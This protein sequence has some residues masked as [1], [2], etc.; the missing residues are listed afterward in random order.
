MTSPTVEHGFGSLLVQLGFRTG[1]RFA[2]RLAPLGLEPRQF[3]ALSRIA[4]AEG[5]SQQAIARQLAL[6]PARMVFVVDELERLGLAERRKNPADR[7]SHALYLTDRGRD[8]LVR[9]QQVAAEYERAIGEPLTEAERARLTELLH[10]LAAAPDARLRVTW[11]D[12]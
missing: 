4:V 3:S 2:Q 11:S 5:E 9:A 7:R 6:T 10:K 12:G 1:V 8:L